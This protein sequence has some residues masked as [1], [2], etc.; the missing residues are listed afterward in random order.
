MF[1]RGAIKYAVRQKSGGISMR[2]VG[3]A[4]PLS[5]Q[6]LLEAAAKIN[7]DPISLWA[8]VSVET[9]GKGF[10]PDRRP[11]YD[12]NLAAAHTRFLVKGFRTSIA[13]RRSCFFSTMVSILVA[14]MA[15]RAQK[16]RKRLRPSATRITGLFLEPS[17]AC[18]LRC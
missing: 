10:L 18:S 15:C 3:R 17:I 8:V 7:T 13:G 12:Q 14:S 9:S 16:Q 1:A 11:Q 4:S 6:G 5:K 2:F